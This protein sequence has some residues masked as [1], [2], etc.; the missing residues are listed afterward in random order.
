MHR[1][2]LVYLYYKHRKNR[3]TEPAA[4]FRRSAASHGA[5]ADFQRAI[6]RRA[7]A[8]VDLQAEIS[9]RRSSTSRCSTTRPT[10]PS[11]WL[12]GL[13]ERYAA[14]GNPISYHHR[15]NREGFKAGAL[16]EGMKT[17]KGEFVAIFDADFTPPE[18]FLLRV[19]PSLYRSED[20]HGA[21][22][23][24]APQ[25][26]LLFSDRGRGDSARRPFRAGA[27]GPRAHGTVLQLQRH[28]RHV[29]AQR[30]STK[31]EAGSTT[32]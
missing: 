13:V 12:A 21:D 11:R 29:A 1:Y 23:L 22:A 30:R 10:K 19:D 32:R 2:I 28:R 26:A 7:T 8:G 17:A 6:R 14:L 9:A 20:R 15:T 4:L 27:L 5:A 25:P 24:D 31:P 18:D 3:T 16:A